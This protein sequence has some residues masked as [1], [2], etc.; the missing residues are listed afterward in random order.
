M[1]EKDKFRIVVNIIQAILIIISTILIF[2]FRENNITVCYIAVLLIFLSNILFWIKDMKKRILFFLFNGSFFIFLMGREAINLLQYG[3]IVYDFEIEIQ[4]H[5]LL[6]LYLSLLALQLGYMICEKYIKDRNSSKNSTIMLFKKNMNREQ[7]KEILKKYAKIV[8]IVGW[9]LNLFVSLEQIIYVANYSY[10]EFVKAFTSKI[11]YIIRICANFRTIA[12]FIFLATMPNKKEVKPIIGMY[13]IEA[14]IS[15]LFGNRGNCIIDI[16]IVIFYIVFRQWK[17]KEEKWITK[18]QV[19]VMVIMIPF[20]FAFLSAMVY[21]REGTNVGEIN[22][23]GQITR[24]FKSIGNSINVLGYEKKYETELNEIGN[25]YTLGDLK[26]YILYNPITEKLF[27]AKHAPY[28]TKEYALSGQSF[29]HTISYLINNEN[30]IDG[31]GNGSVYIAELHIDF[32]YIGVI[33]GNILL[34]AYMA[35]FYKIYEKSYIITGSLL[36]S[37]RIMFFIPRAPIDYIITYVFN[38]TAI[39]SV[40]IILLLTLGEI[41]IK[42]RRKL[43]KNE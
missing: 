36:L 35:M 19:I 3:K 17:A 21:L 14:V 8:F 11:P 27:N 31:H 25:L 7:F 42:N 2:I 22:L 9:I 37:Y 29:M 28:H 12:F 26:Q 33:I 15:L 38:I 20:V 23:S 32:G 41:Y 40:I 16:L 34:G 5:I 10:L 18:K 39:V 24:F 30:Y 43:M 6:C 13:I 4:F 1:K